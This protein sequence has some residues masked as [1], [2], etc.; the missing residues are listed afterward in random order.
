MGKEKR[1]LLFIILLEIV[2]VAFAFIAGMATQQWLVNRPLQTSPYPLLTEAINILKNH[3]LEA[4]PD[5]GKLEHGMIRGLLQVYGDPYTVFVEPSQHELQ[6]N[7]LEGK[8]GGIGARLERTADQNVLLYPYEDSPASL[9]GI[10][11]GDRLL[12][13]ED[14]LLEPETSFEVIQAAIRGPVGQPVVLR[15]VRLPALEEYTFSVIRQEISLPSVTWNLSAEAAQVGIVQINTIAATTP[16]EVARAIAELT[17][18]GAS[19]F[20]L[21]LRNNAGGLV[22]A[23][24]D[25]ARLFLDQG[26]V[27]EQQYRSQAVTSFEV[28]KPGPFVD[29]PLV[30][31]VNRGTASAAEIIAGGLQAQKR[32]KLVGSS[33]YGKNTIQLV[34]ELQ[35]GS[36]I[37]VTSARWWVPGLHSSVETGLQPDVNFPEEQSQDPLL[38]E[39]AVQLVLEQVA[40]DISR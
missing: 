8:F 7:Q 24:V 14:L 31:L 4:L 16:A 11:P 39:T 17:D 28:E 5:A 32:A 40:S 35:D 21:D 10:K 13:I 6:T 1:L 25:T 37:H 22:E 26:V 20:I 3:A 38:L 12:A 15:V 36:S 23:G 18:Q 30:V 19:H 27:I 2:L 29:L 33:T 34:F 9:A